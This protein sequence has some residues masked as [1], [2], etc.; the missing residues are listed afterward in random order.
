MSALSQAG[1]EILLLLIF[2]VLLYDFL[3]IYEAGLAGVEHVITTQHEGSPKVLNHAAIFG[4]EL[5]V[6]DHSTSVDDLFTCLQDDMFLHDWTN[7]CKDSTDVEQ[8][9]YEA[10]NVRGIRRLAD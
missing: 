7:V 2:L 1:L 5:H 6:V 8:D 9:H 4:N 10:R 3:R